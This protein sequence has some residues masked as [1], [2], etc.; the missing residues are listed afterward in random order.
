MGNGRFG[1]TCVTTLAWMM[2]A[3]GCRGSGSDSGSGGMTGGG[4]TSSNGGT[5]GSGGSPASGGSSGTTNCPNGSS[6]G[7]ELVGSWKVTSSCLQLAG[8]MDGYLLYL[9]CEKVPVTGSLKVTG[10]WTASANGTF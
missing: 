2:A 9:G 5:K 1:L 3:I 8:D 7:G 4:G 6:C 10:T